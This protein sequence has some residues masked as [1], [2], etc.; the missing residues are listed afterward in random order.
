MSKV[1]KLVGQIEAAEILEISEYQLV[2]LTAPDGPIPCFRMS[3]FNLY[4]VDD[5]SACQTWLELA[6][7]G[8]PESDTDFI[9]PKVLEW[10]LAGKE[11]CND[12]TS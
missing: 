2:V 10:I 1:T 5:L 11:K 6:E 3:G 8:F 4:S 7:E 12:A 9:E